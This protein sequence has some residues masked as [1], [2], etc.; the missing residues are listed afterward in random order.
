MKFNEA[1]K[2]GG[3]AVN[4]DGVYG[5]W[6][7]GTCTLSQ[8]IDSFTN[9]NPDEVPG[10]DWT[11]VGPVVDLSD[12]PEHNTL[13]ALTYMDDEFFACYLKEDIEGK[14]L[15]VT[16]PCEECEE[17]DLERDEQ[18]REI[19]LLVQKCD[20][21]EER[22][23]ELEAENH[24]M[25]ELVS[26][27]RDSFDKGLKMAA[28][29][30]T[31]ELQDELARTK[32]QRDGWK[33]NQ[34]SAMRKL[35][36]A[37][38]ELAKLENYSKGQRERIE[39]LEKRCG[40]LEAELAEAEKKIEFSERYR[41]EFKKIAEYP[42]DL[43]PPWGDLC[44]IIDGMLREVREELAEARKAPVL[45]EPLTREEFE[46][47]SPEA[48]IL[49]KTSQGQVCQDSKCYVCFDLD[50]RWL[51][52]RP[53][54]T[55]PEPEEVPE[56]PKWLGVVWHQNRCKAGFVYVNDTDSMFVATPTGFV[57]W[58]VDNLEIYRGPVK[59]PDG[60]IAPI[61]P[62]PELVEAVEGENE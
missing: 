8:F 55:L 46:G 61:E 44:V 50:R 56:V 36:K 43:N 38:A 4:S 17:S 2:P 24:K 45:G 30:D 23:Q 35:R 31:K 16:K 48:P 41:Q 28:T 1:T 26:T 29:G 19:E 18:R 21:K 49:Y 27:L 14:A 57:R 32:H 25:L 54:P 9:F 10:D 62:S 40:E 7:A 3:C 12:V 47:L 11:P 5:I 15:Q 42:E 60:T 52:P 13:V 58:N 51:D 34:A 37:E 59:H 33:N 53:M 39:W 22:I 6:R 20:A